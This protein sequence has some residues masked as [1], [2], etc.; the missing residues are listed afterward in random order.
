MIAY[1][2]R[3][4]SR[5][6]VAEGAPGCSEG[7]EKAGSSG[8]A[9]E[10]WGSKQ[11][12]K[13]E[14]S[15]YVIE[16]KG[17]HLQNELKRTQIEPQLSAEMRALRVKFEFSSTSQVL[18]EASNGK[19]GRTNRPVGGIRRTAREY[20]NR[21]NEAKKYL[22]TKDITFLKCCK[23]RVFCA[24]MNSNLTSKDA[25]GATF[26]ENEVRT[27]DSQRDGMTVT[28]SRLDKLGISIGADLIC[29]RA[30]ASYG[31]IVD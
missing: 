13:Y 23:F 4:F 28:N 12:K 7:E 16:N 10:N 31:R 30:A 20:E 14:R 19:G 18:A 24:Q 8:R 5:R 27:C 1:L 9:G 21:G 11:Q 2:V 29:G 25:N 22:K 26:C 15:Q 3:L 6:F 17:R